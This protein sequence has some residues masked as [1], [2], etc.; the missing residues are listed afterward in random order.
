[1]TRST[2]SSCIRS[3]RSRFTYS[4]E[5]TAS[6]WSS[7]AVLET[8]SSPRGSLARSAPTRWSRAA[9]PLTAS[10]WSLVLRLV[11]LAFGTSSMESWTLDTSGASSLMWF[12][13]AT[14][15]RSTTCSPF[16]ALAQSSLSWSTSTRELRKKSSRFT[17][18]SNRTS[19]L[20]SKTTSWMIHRT[21]MATT[22][23]T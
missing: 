22:R 6:D 3:S 8:R 13:T 11:L 18:A 15:T 10:T 4:L 19:P 5:T 21:R 14:G 20:A 2:R 1:M 17:T 9:S 16:Q 12:R 7:T 23:Q